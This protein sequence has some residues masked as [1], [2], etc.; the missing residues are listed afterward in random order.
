M[1]STRKL[2][3]SR[4]FW[5]FGAE[6]SR[7]HIANVFPGAA[8][9]HPK[10]SRT[11]AVGSQSGEPVYRDVVETPCWRWSGEVYRKYGYGADSL[12]YGSPNWI[13]RISSGT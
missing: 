4:V 3:T 13:F 7:G 10:P 9:G 6:E 8:T 2:G 11:D 12:E 5:R 1:W